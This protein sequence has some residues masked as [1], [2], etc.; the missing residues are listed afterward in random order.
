MHQFFQ[1]VP[2]WAA[3]E[4]KDVRRLEKAVACCQ[5]EVGDVLF[6]EGDPCSG[7]HFVK[8]GLIG[9]RKSALDG[10]STL[11]KILRAGDSL[12]IRSLTAEES[13]RATAKV[14]KRSLVCF[15]DAANIR[16]VIQQNLTLG[17]NLLKHTAV[18]LGEADERYHE[19][20]TRNLRSR[21]A[22]LLMLLKDDDVHVGKTGIL[23]F[24]LPVSRTDMAAML[25][26]R[27]ESV[28]R[29]IH[30]FEQEG[31]AHFTDRNVEI[32]DQNCLQAEFQP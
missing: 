12:G 10:Y 9:L 26:V 22:H 14:L 28:S 7:V 19:M 27:R 4:A 32:P 5:F 2:Q 30:E 16:S 21:L 23:R 11:L 25:G 17:N 24:E 20:A 18:E 6:K 13:H 3:L 29:T 31:L 15:I 8:S 1:E